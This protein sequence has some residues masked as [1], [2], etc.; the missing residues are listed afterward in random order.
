[1]KNMYLVFTIK[2]ELWSDG[3]QYNVNA[4]LTL[5]KMKPVLTWYDDS[6][7]TKGEPL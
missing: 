2:W 1:M 3:E 6:G 4:A 7:G 5:L